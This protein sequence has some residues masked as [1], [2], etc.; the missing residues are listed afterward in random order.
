MNVDISVCIAN[1][2]GAAVLRECLDSVISQAVPAQVEILVFDDASSDKSGHIA[3]R[4][5]PEV[6]SICSDENVGF[7][8]ACNALADRASGRFLLFLN[9]DAFLDPGALAAL[10]EASQSAPA[11]IL[12][13]RQ[14]DAV[15]GE[16]L[17]LGMGLD[18]LTV[19]FPLKTSPSEQLV[20]CIGACLWVSAALFDEAGRF[21]AWFGSIAEDL[22]LCQFAR[23]RGHDVKVIAEHSYRHHSG[24]SFGGGKADQA[25][26]STSYRRR[27]LSERNRCLVFLMFFPKRALFPLLPVWLLAWLLEAIALSV[28]QRSLEPSSKIYWQAFRDVIQM[29]G[30]VLEKRRNIMAGKKISAGEFLAPLS[31]QPTKLRHLLRH[32]LPSL[33]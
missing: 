7:C 8:R 3:H 23:T 9:N 1:Y 11:S 33:R 2:N 12:T 24:L 14:I 5:Y 32:G 4:E 21:P 10:W 15:S 19:P 17:D 22:Y 27:Y 29:R 31:W 16:L 30:L 28:A 26:Q 20:T 18:I 6:I 13:L 25:G